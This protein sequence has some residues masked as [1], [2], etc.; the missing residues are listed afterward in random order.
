MHSLN[1]AGWH[2]D[3]IILYKGDVLG[4]EC[5]KES[6]FACKNCGIHARLGNLHYA[7]IIAIAV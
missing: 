2:D 6:N 4:G 1:F 5:F 7:R 3:I